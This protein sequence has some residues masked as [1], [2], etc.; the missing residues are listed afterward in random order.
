MVN[1]LPGV[2]VRVTNCSPLIPQLEVGTI[3][4]VTI[5]QEGKEARVRLQ[6][7]SLNRRE[8][9]IDCLLVGTNVQL[10]FK[11]SSG[12]WHLVLADQNQS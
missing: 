4:S 7:L 5:E 3:A 10:L 12:G 2:Q 11:G 1:F 9:Q 6:V 8:W